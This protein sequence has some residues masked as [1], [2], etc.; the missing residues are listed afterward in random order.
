MSL[1]MNLILLYTDRFTCLENQKQLVKISILFFILRA[2]RADINSYF[3]TVSFKK[4]VEY[5]YLF[6]A[7]LRYK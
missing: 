1:Q 2:L 5:L 3:L 6:N 7:P 4:I